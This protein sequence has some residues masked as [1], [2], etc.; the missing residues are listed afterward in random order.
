MCPFPSFVRHLIRLALPAFATVFAMGVGSASS[1]DAGDQKNTTPPGGGWVSDQPHKKLT[2]N[3]EP[4]QP[5]G[6]E[7][8]NYEMALQYSEEHEG[9]SMLVMKHGEIAFEA[10][11]LGRSPRQPHYLASGTKTFWGILAAA[12]VDDGLFTFDEL[13]CE[14]I[15]EW[16][17]HPRKSCI[18]VRH[19]LT[20]TSGLAPSDETFDIFKVYDLYDHAISDAIESTHEPGTFFEY[21]SSPFY[22]FAAFL[23]RKLEP[24]NITVEQYM[25]R[26][27]FKPIGLKV[28]RWGKDRAGNLH[29]PS[30]AELTA[31]EW[32][33]LGELIRNKG[34]VGEKQV[35]DA[36]VLAECFM[37]G[38][39]PSYGLAIWLGER[40]AQYLGWGPKDLVSA[41]GAGFQRL[42]V[43]PS[44]GLTIVRQGEQCEPPFKDD[45]FLARLL[46]GKTAEEVR[47]S[48]PSQTGGWRDQ[49]SSR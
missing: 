14:T 10:Y 46:H 37:P 36:Q 26:R 35:I 40:Q 23:R 34:K 4:R 9:L 8:A 16:K 13:I 27:L 43:I 48:S 39:M 41:V 29:T 11:A 30:G 42:H 44:L 7:L 25:K 47:R 19:L 32:A 31:R 15:T 2:K 38:P 3:D 12:A 33:K 45:E 22:A 6:E 21:G 1:I 49:S 28:A 20:L 5:T 18:T 24:Q 17:D